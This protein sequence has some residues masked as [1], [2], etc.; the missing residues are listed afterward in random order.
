MPRVP[1]KPSK[2]PTCGSKTITM[3]NLGDMN[4]KKCGYVRLSDYSLKKLQKNDEEMENYK[5]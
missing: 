3:N 5:E 2:C 4:C 1:K